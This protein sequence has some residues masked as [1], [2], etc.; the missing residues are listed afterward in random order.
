MNKVGI[1]VI[2]LVVIVGALFFFSNNAAEAPKN[3]ELQSPSVTGARDLPG[4]QVASDDNM[5]D[6]VDTISQTD[7]S[8]VVENLDS[9]I[10]D[11]IKERESENVVVL[12]VRTDWEWNELH[13]EGAMHY[14]LEEFLQKGDLPD[15]DKNVEIYVYCRTGVRAA[16]AIRILQEAGYTNLKNIRSIDDWV[17]NGGPTVTGIDG[18][19]Q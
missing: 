12:D 11:V 8:P 1:G 2:A 10:K 3:N 7:M 13:A 4:S 17:R 18:D 14:G 6:A 16:Q 9:V 19:N 5:A 15:I